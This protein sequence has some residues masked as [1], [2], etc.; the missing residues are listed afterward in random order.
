M[1]QH[2]PLVEALAR[3]LLRS[4]PSFVEIDDLVAFGRLGLVEA[5]RRFDPSR[6]IL[7]KTFAYYRI[8]GAIY[9]GIRK[10]SW[11]RGSA[12]REITYDS[13]SNELLRESTE[14]T[15]AG[16]RMI[17]LEEQIEQT[18]DIIEKIAAAKILSLNSDEAPID[19]ADERALP[20]EVTEVA[21]LS[22]VMRACVAKLDEKERSVIEDYYFNHL[23]LEEAGAKIGLSKSWTCRLHARALKK[24]LTLVREQGLEAPS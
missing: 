21:E 4:L 3:K 15:A 1:D 11:F 5:S 12:N 9:D 22:L 2:L 19:L 18:K 7:F 6:G 17:S 10:M 16:H 20:D 8:R 23:N 14:S 24:L 13:A